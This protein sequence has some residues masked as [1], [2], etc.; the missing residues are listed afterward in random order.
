MP[1]GTGGRLGGPGAGSEKTEKTEG[2]AR[3]EGYDT[4]R[5]FFVREGGTAEEGVMGGRAVGGAV[6]AP[7][8][9]SPG[10]PR[11]GGIGATAKSALLS[12]DGDLRVEER[13]VEGGGDGIGGR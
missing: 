3:T 10:A 11:N 9:R 7:S 2:A 1:F 4:R 13:V 8:R 6:A 12:F 5:S